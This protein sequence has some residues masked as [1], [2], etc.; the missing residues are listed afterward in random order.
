MIFL[1]VQSTFKARASEWVL[2]S[3]LSSI[4]LMLLRPDDI[5]GQSSVYI[6]LAQIASQHTWGWFCLVGGAIRLVAL[7]INGY[8]IPSS[9]HLRALTAFLGCLFWFQFA[10]GLFVSDRPTI[11]LV[12]VPWLFLMDLINCHRAA[13]DANIGRER[14]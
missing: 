9:Y 4:G 7:T 6:G 1:H 12:T 2:A 14:H 3:I 5:F 11:I 13:V 8:W 10:L